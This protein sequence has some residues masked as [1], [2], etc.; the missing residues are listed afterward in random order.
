MCQFMRPGSGARQPWAIAGAI[1]RRPSRARTLLSLRKLPIVEPRL[2]GPAHDR[3]L[4]AR[5]PAGGEPLFGGC[6]AQAIIQTFPEE[7][8]YL[9][10]RHRQ[11]VRTNIHRARELG[12]TATRL[13][14]YDEFAAACAPVYRSRPGGEAVLAAMRRPAVTSG[15]FAWYA[16]STPAHDAPVIV[17]A[18]ALFGDF[19]VLAVMVGNLDYDRIGYA[20]YLMHTFILG[21]LAAHGIQ[22]LIVGS[23]LRESTG[24]QYFQRLLGYRICNLRPILLPPSG[25]RQA[26]SV[27]A[28]TRRL[29][30]T[31]PLAETPTPASITDRD[32]ARKDSQRLTPVPATQVAGQGEWKAV[33]GGLEPSSA[34]GIALTRGGSE[35]RG[36]SL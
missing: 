34:A 13:D 31:G 28:A 21:D 26:G 19:G 23:V 11:A 27:A 9:T 18:V 4:Q 6:W 32:A 25:S 22:H 30:M 7:H 2:S 15:E 33:A 36:S 1:A 8:E 16:A 20:R 10:G 5:W 24:N 14:G 12:I 35:D 17:A 29:L 3:W